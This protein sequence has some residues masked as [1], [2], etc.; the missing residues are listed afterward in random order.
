M[1]FEY[2]AGRDFAPT[3]ALWDAAL[4]DWRALPSDADARFD[5]EEEIAA[6]EIAPQITWGTSPEH[7]A[8]VTGAVPADAPRAALDY[9]GLER[10]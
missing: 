6:S 8:P 3:G 4:A 2:L 5:R 9:M 10:G 7:V 1:A